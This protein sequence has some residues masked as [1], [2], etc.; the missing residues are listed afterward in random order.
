M[1]QVNNVEYGLAPYGPDAGMRCFVIH[2]DDDNKGNLGISDLDP[3]K[4]VEK[5]GKVFYDNAERLA[6]DIDNNIK[7]IGK[8]DLWIECLT[9]PKFKE[10]IYFS[11]RVITND[12]YFYVINMLLQVISKKSLELQKVIH[13]AG[14][15]IE[16]CA[17][18]FAIISYANS[19]Y[20][21][22]NIWEAC[23]MT[24]AHLPTEIDGTRLEFMNKNDFYHING[25]TNIAKS[26][27]GS[28]VF[29]VS[30]EDDLKLF[31]EFYEPAMVFK[32]RGSIRIIPTNNKVK[33]AAKKFAY[34]NCFR[35]N[36][37]MSGDDFVNFDL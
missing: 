28:F 5:I 8:E 9:Q 21:K 6:T 7:K 30:S 14:Q 22:K 1:I 25:L 24:I 15:K 16:L 20:I 37:E 35:Y 11:G 32:S 23:N 29:K 26:S 10:Y 4:D 27:F 18:K 3:Q 2:L 34:E 13:D 17:P 31:K 19:P 12:E 33:D 36:E